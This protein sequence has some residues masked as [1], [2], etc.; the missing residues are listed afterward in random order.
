MTRYLVASLLTSFSDQEVR[1]SYQHIFKQPCL[2]HTLHLTYIPPFHLTKGDLP[3]IPGY[4]PLPPL[5]IISFGLFSVT[6]RQILYAQ[7]DSPILHQWA[8]ELH[9]LFNPHITI[10][11]DNFPSHVEPEFLPHI[12]LDYDYKGTSLLPLKS[13]LTIQLQPPQL[14]CESARGVWIPTTSSSC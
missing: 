2:V 1:T 12:S 9:T 7:L 10:L 13:K 8:T 4:Q 14:L 11:S 3:D 5:P 6:K